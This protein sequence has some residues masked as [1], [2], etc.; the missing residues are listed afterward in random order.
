MAK[1]IKDI[2]VTWAWSGDTYAIDGFNVAIAPINTD[3]K[4]NSTISAMAV[5]NVTSYK[6]TG[7]TL[8]DSTQYTAWVQAVYDGGDSDW[9]SAGNLTVSDD[10]NA[11]IATKTQVTAI[12]NTLSD[13]ANDNKLTPVEKQDVLNEWNIITNEKTNIDSQADI[14]SI[15]TEKTTYD[16]SYTALGTFLNGGTTYTSGT[17]SWISDVKNASPATIDMTSSGGGDAFRTAFNNY[18]AARTALLKK[19]NEMA[20]STIDGIKVGTK[21][22]IT[23]SKAPY[24][25]YCG[26]GATPNDSVSTVAINTYVNGVYIDNIRQLSHTVGNTGDFRISNVWNSN[27]DANTTLTPVLNRTFMFSG[28]VKAS[29]AMNISLFITGTLDNDSTSKTFALT[30]NTWTRIEMLKTFTSATQ[31][32]VRIR[33]TTDTT[34]TMQIALVKLEESN[35]SSDWSPAPEDGDAAVS[36]VRTDLRLT[37]PLPSTISMDANGITATTTADATAYSRMDYRG[38]Y[39]AKGAVQID[40]GTGGVSLSGASGL[41]ATQGSGTNR[42][43]V[44]LNATDGIK[45]QKST[46]SGATFPTT[47]FNVD[48]S[49]NLNLTG[50]ITMLSGSKIQWAST[51]NA[52]TPLNYINSREQNLVTNGNGQLK[53]NTNFTGFTFDGTDSPDGTTGSFKYYGTSATKMSDE[54]IPVNVNETYNLSMYLKAG[55]EVASQYLYAGLTPYDIDGNAIDPSNYLC[56]PNTTTTL[57]QSLK[58]GDTVVYLTSTTGWN[59]AVGTATYQRRLIFWNYAN[60]LGYTYPV[61]TYSRNLSASDL[62]A[63]GAINTTTKAITLRSAWTGSTIAAGTSVSQATSGNSYIYCLMINGTVPTTWTH[64]QTSISGIQNDGNSAVTKFPPGT[65]GV[66]ILFLANYGQGTT[67]ATLKVSS[68]QFTLGVGNNDFNADN[69]ASMIVND[70]S[71]LNFLSNNINLTGKVKFSSFDPNDT[72]TDIFTQ[73][74]DGLTTVIDG[75]RISTKTIAANDAILWNGL[76]VKRAQKKKDANGNDVLDGNGNPIW[77]DG[78]SVFTIDSQTRHISMQGTVQSMNYLQNQAGWIIKEDGS[79]EFNSA[80]FRGDVEVG[81]YDTTNK[82]YVAS[83]G[84]KTGTS[85]VAGQADVR[86]WAGTS[87]T[88]AAFK[89]YSDG[90]LE[91]KQGN[92]QGT[93]SG[94]VQVGNITISDNVGV[95]GDASFILADINKTPLITLNETNAIFAVPNIVVG[96]SNGN[97]VVFTPANGAITLGTNGWLIDY[98]NNIL[99][100]NGFSIFGDNTSGLFI[101]S[102]NSP[103][104]DITFKNKLGDVEVYVDGDLSIK[105]SI[106][107]NSKLTMRKATDVGNTGIDFVFN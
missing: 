28:W 3:P 14:Y 53:D 81:Y 89:V 12:N 103:S 75:G 74:P 55:T 73:S 32:G 76:Q 68:I 48:T 94:V 85:G 54:I 34:G 52:Q 60:S 40:A 97:Q 86:F 98:D 104:T 91:A 43:K 95:A 45:I 2:T 62:W 10:G 79:A 58:P 30:A 101:Q 100:M 23:N 7:V 15:T 78:D 87:P 80:V 57:A 106:T 37:A 93:F 49:G 72:F 77:E 5:G 59:N 84:I 99:N 9:I 107:V 39:I 92:F 20:K 41:I 46:D 67:S 65:A 56:M 70:G 26:Y 6:F 8:D 82:V 69:I 96:P 21:N 64:Y 31:T 33:V 44:S 50:N 36:Q 11:T 63:D 17:P 18:Y 102:N 19:V 61:N 29:V 47:T 4:T 51:G 13:I 16:N 88:N 27:G 35:K 25:W 24:L 1:I 105:N 66:K 83:A 42:V 71:A 90:T 38:L 22:L